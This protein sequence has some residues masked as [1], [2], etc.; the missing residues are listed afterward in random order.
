MKKIVKTVVTI[1]ALAALTI[2]STFAAA[3]SCCP[4]GDCCKGGSCCKAKH[5]VKK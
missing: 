5:H 3:Q 1:A 2:G 4:S